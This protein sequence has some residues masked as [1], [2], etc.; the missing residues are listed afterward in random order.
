MADNVPITAGSGT[1]VATDE[2]AGVHY[3]I[4]KQAFGTLDTAT[5]VSASNP[6]PVT[7]SNASIP[8]TGTFWQATQPISAAA[9]PL[10]TGAATAAKQPA[11]GTAGSSSTDVLTVQ[12]IASMTALK[13]DGS[14]VT[15]PVS[16]SSLP[17]PTG[18]ATSANQSTLNTNI[19]S[20]ADA[21]VANG[22]GGSIAGY[23]RAIK[24]AA[25]DTTTASPVSVRTPCD[26]VPLTPTL[27]TLAYASGDT[28]FATTLLSGAT[29]ANDERALLQSLVLID[30]A[31]NNPAMTLY[32]F[33]GNAAFGTINTAPSV[34]DA[35]MASYFL[36]TVTIAA[37]DWKT[38]T[39]NSNCTKTAIGLILEAASGT[40]NVYVAATLDAGTPTY[41]ASDLVLNFGLVFS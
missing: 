29:R 5:L 23:L 16:A 24:D 19:G 21:A 22:S 34:S 35:D 17:L 12:G 8:V 32:F 36:G 7:V 11:L 26:M 3:Q 2:I 6:F 33:K 41:A 18:A 9:L 20:S 10:P 13:V 1:S 15:Q 27:D 25:T 31:K 14:A 28:L 37:S 30:R 39:N 38:L 40:T 4:V